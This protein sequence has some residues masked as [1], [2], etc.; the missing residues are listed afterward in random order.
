LAREKRARDE[1]HNGVVRKSEIF[2]I[3]R[4]S[5][6]DDEAERGPQEAGEDEMRG[7]AVAVSPRLK[8]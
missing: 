7:C 6:S 1:K 3:T 8:E 2:V 5:L 4:A